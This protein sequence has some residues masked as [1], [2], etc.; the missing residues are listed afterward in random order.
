MEAKVSL[1]VLPCCSVESARAEAE[2]RAAAHAAGEEVLRLRLEQMHKELGSL[3]Q[4]LLQITSGRTAVGGGLGG[5]STGGH[6]ED[7][8][9]TPEKLVVQLGEALH[10]LDHWRDKAEESQQLL[11]DVSV[12]WLCLCLCL[13]LLADMIRRTSTGDMPA[14]VHW[15]MICGRGSDKECCLD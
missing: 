5:M 10:E 2:A 9:L 12:A 1:V 15:L 3:Q 11:D 8:E 13:C 7:I 6:P 14:G 4:E